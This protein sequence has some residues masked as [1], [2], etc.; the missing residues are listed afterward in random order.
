MS[1]TTAALARRLAEL[2]RRVESM[3]TETPNL[4]TF[5]GGSP[6]SVPYIESGGSCLGF[7]NTTGSQLTLDAASS[8]S[9]ALLD[10][11]QTY[12]TNNTIADGK[13]LKTAGGSV[14]EFGDGNYGDEDTDI[15]INL[16]LDGEFTVNYDGSP[17]WGN[18]GDTLRIHGIVDL[19]A[20]IIP[21]TSSVYDL[22]ADG[23]TFSSLYLTGSNLFLGGPRQLTFFMMR[24]RNNSGTLQYRIFQ[25]VNYADKIINASVSYQSLL[26]I[27]ASNDFASGHWLGRLS[28]DT[29]FLYMNTADQDTQA[30]F[31]LANLEETT[32]TGITTLAYIRP[33]QDNIGGSNIHRPRISFDNV[34]INTTNIAAG[35]V[36]I[37]KI[38][39]FLK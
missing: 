28:T 23:N 36:I 39:G 31:I 1:D 16:E 13:H 38:F 10:V 27:D 15:V 30:P 14:I 5:C 2:E 33:V 32:A 12:T 29:R 26:D 25:S 22:G 34:A 6:K 18:M 8:G 11:E 20:D 17:V 21:D 19:Q 4:P 9:L 3:M 37:V 7:T 35:E 24:I